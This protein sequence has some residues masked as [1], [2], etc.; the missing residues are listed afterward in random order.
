MGNII[1]PKVW[2]RKQWQLKDFVSCMCVSE[3]RSTPNRKPVKNQAYVEYHIYQLWGRNSHTQIIDRWHCR[4]RSWPPIIHCGSMP[5]KY[6]IATRN[7]LWIYARKFKLRRHNHETY[8]V[9]L[10]VTNYTYSITTWTKRWYRGSSIPSPKSM[11][12]TMWLHVLKSNMVETTWLP[13]IVETINK[14]EG[15]HH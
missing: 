3:T 7:T 8:K 10:C 9:D 13:I 11:N 6:S 1:P 14:C 2:G 4:H 15:N 12:L 5:S